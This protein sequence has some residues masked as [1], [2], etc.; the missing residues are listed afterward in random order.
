ME[1]GQR[2]MDAAASVGK[3]LGLQGAFMLALGAS[4]K[5]VERMVGRANARPESDAG[6]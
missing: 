5:T 4:A 1:L 6:D 3:A 2:R